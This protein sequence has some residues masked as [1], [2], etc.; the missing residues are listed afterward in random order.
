MGAP[1]KETLKYRHSILIVDDEESILNA[2]R[3]ILA[4]EDYDVHTAGN[5]KEALET[6]RAAREPFSLIISDQR[7]PVMSGV[8]FLAAS[9]EIFPDAVR[10]L[11]T[12]YADKEA[13]IDAVNKGGIHFYLT[14]PWREEELLAHIRQSLLKTELLMENRRLVELIKRQNEELHDFN[15]TL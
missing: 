15:R 14:K 9:R 8:Q 1:E 13:I 3:R 12:G 10:I 4:D 2:F 11:L 5:G 6:L 7:M